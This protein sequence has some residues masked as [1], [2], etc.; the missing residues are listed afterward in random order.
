G[1]SWSG[2]NLP[3]ASEYSMAGVSSGS[4]PQDSKTRPIRPS[5][6]SEARISPAEMSERPFG[7]R[8][9]G[10]AG[11]VFLLIGGNRCRK[12]DVRSQIAEIEYQHQVSCVLIVG[13]APH[14]A[15]D[16]RRPPREGGVKKKA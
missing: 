5:M 12:S 16:A 14:P 1:R 11:S 13:V 9:S 8:A 15:R 10:R 4:K 3:S 2:R 7:R 6:S